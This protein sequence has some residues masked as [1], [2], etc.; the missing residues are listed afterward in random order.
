MMVLRPLDTS[1]IRINEL[2]I[3]LINISFRFSNNCSGYEDIPPI[4]N[5][6]LGATGMNGLVVTKY[7]VTYLSDCMDTPRM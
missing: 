1:I 4:E 5:R 3:S 2:S 6:F 7:T